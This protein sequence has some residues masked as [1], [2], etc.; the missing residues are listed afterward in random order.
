MELVIAGVTQRFDVTFEPAVGDSNPLPVAMSVYDVTNGTPTLVAGPTAMTIV[1]STNSYFGGFA[2]ILNHSYLILKAVYQ[3]GTFAA[4]DDEY[5]QGSETILAIANPSTPLNPPSVRS[6]IGIVNNTGQC[7]G[8]GFPVFEMFQGDDTPLPLKAMYQNTFNPLDLTD[9]TEIV[10][11]IT[12]TDGTVQQFKLTNND[13]VISGD[14]K[15]GMFVVNWTTLI[16]A[17]FMVGPLQNIDVAF[18]I[19]GEITTIR[20]YNCLS[21]FQVV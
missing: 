18:T 6:I 10:V 21:V 1:P 20:Y 5:T 4:F 2:P 8:Y 17:N 19:D 15:L 11:N 13:V 3:D 16:S 14:P 12:N 7:N 9:C